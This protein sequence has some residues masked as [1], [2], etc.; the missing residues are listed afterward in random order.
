MI[1]S[2]FWLH[3]EK[4]NYIM[5]ILNATSQEGCFV[6]ACIKIGHDGHQL[7]PIVHVI[8]KIY[9]RLIQWCWCKMRSVVS[10][11][12]GQKKRRGLNLRAQNFN[13]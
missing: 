4:K 5:P 12:G 1:A 13:G 8:I 10:S 2:F 3:Y 6:T 9:I 11:L 7:A